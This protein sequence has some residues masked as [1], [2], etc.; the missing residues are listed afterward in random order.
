MAGNARGFTLIELMVVIAIVAILVTMTVSVTKAQ[1]SGNPKGISDQVNSLITMTRQRAVANR[2]YHKVEILPHEVDVWQWSSFGMATPSGACP[3]N[4]WQ[5]LQK[6]VIP[7]EGQIW[8][9][10]STVYATTGYTGGQNTSLDAEIDLRPDGSSTGG[11]VF[12]TNQVNS[13]KY[14]VLVYKTTGSSYARQGW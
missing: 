6:I 8:D 12:I 14:R 3:P 2:R 4:C 1:Y 5:F 13:E 11:T 7:N 9:V 10:S